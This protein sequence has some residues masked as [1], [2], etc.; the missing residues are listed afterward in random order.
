MHTQGKDVGAV[1]RISGRYADKLIAPGEIIFAAVA[2]NI[3]TEQERFP[4]IVVLTNLRAIA[5]CGLPGIKRSISFPFGELEKYEEVPSAIRYK[6][7]F[8]SLKNVF[9]MSVDPDTGERFARTIAVLNGMA[10]AFDAAGTNVDSSI[11]NPVLIRNKLRARHSKA[12][13]LENIRS[14]QEFATSVHSQS[15]TLEQEEADIQIIAQHLAQQLAEAKSK[16]PVD[17][18]APKAVAARLTAEL[19]AENNKA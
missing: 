10:D 14:H 3:A 18:K 2:A 15:H 8:F 11:I 9:S 5:V 12:K 16:G 6:I 4:G 17:D 13:K 7:T 19:A 1:N